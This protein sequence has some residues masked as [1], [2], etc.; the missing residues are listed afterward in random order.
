M[1]P[2]TLRYLNDVECSTRREADKVVVVLVVAVDEMDFDVAENIL[3]ESRV[4]LRSPPR[5]PAEVAG[6]K[7]DVGTMIENDRC[8]H[9]PFPVRV[10][11][12]NNIFPMNALIHS[13]NSNFLESKNFWGK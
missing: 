1:V 7:N 2:D 5:P 8:K 4:R 12:D 9:T 13:I 6:D 10:P 11:N 3:R